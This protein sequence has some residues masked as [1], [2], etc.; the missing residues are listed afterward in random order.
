MRETLTTRARPVVREQGAR[1]NGALERRAQK[2]E[3]CRGIRDLIAVCHGRLGQLS[4]LTRP[5]RRTTLD[6]RWTIEGR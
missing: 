1:Q 3:K 2:L 6:G 4:C 5:R